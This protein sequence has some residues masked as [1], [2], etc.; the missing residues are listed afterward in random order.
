MKEI[1]KDIPNYE[2]YYQASNLGNIRSLDRWIDNPNKKAKTNGYIKKKMILKQNKI[3]S[4]YYTTA[5]SREGTTKAYLTHRLIAIAFLSNPLNK[6]QVNHK[7][8]VKTDNN[9]SNLEWATRSENAI[10]SYE[11]KLQ[12]SRKGSLHGSAKL[13][14][15]DVLE[16]R[17]LLLKK[18]DKNQISEVFKISYGTV[19]DIEKRRRWKHI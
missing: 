19:C 13:S 18:V 12:I 6:P 2:G 16:I 9:V 4:G 1:W 11:N 7:N 14:E 5:L 3:K 17:S 8:G 10:H 15:L